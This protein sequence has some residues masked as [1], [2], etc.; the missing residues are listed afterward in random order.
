MV[1]LKQP[2]L[3]GLGRN[4]AAPADVLV[5]LA[6]HEAGRHGL[7]TR[8]GRLPDTVV[9]ALLAHGGR[10]SAVLLHGG[11]VSPA[12]RHQIAGHP[13]PAI[14]NARADFIRS[15]V[16]CGVPMGVESLVEAYG[17]P[18]AELATASDPKLRAM[19]AE[20]WRERPMV[21]QLALL[22]DPDP[23]V[24]AAATMA[25]HPGIP[26]EYYARCLAD[27]AVQANVARRLPLTPD[28]FARLLETGNKTV[29][30]AV[31]RNPNL[32]A[33]MVVQLQDSA[34]PAVRIAVA[35]SRH[36]TPETRDRLL[37]LVE[38]EKETGSIDARVALDGS[39]YEP[40]WLRDTPLAERLTYLDCPHVVFRRVLAACCDLPDEAWQRLDDDP[41]VSV[42][43]TAARRPNTPPQVLV[44]LLRTHGDVSH[45]RPLLVD[46]PNFPRQALR[47]FA[48]EPDPQVRDL[49]LQDPGLPVS[50]LRRIVDSQEEFLRAGAAGHPN[51]TV[52]LLERLLADSE[53]K[54]ADA[55]AANP[56]LPRAQMDRVLTEA[57]L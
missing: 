56:V 24:R 21:V 12:M 34:D 36:V 54:V 4:P 8:R 26:P 5:R 2:R 40:S 43:R 3:S 50:E 14:R 49:A 23:G 22:T 18:A 46:H 55:A 9:E 37:A 57:G 11:R 6:T 33:D 44:R 16:E 45:I 38:A 19:V 47:G 30:R 29:L 35:F 51:V 1:H 52:E 20:T 31:A 42:R 15:M 17:R 7:A 32:S 39:S 25:G 41:D 27:P 10:D 13:D 53:P 28:Q 48:D